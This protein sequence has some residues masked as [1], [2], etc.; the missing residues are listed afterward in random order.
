MSKPHHHYVN[1]SFLDSEFPFWVRKYKHTSDRIPHSHDFVE[2]V[3][4]TAGEALHEY[5]G[6]QYPIGAGDV[7]IINPGE[8]HT[9][10]IA[11]GQELDII[12]C[13]FIPELLSPLLLQELQLVKE[14]DFLYVLPF[15]DGHQRFHHRLKLNGRQSRTLLHLLESMIEEFELREAGHRTLLKMKLIEVLVLLSRYYIREHAAD[16][17]QTAAAD[18]D[19]LRIRRIRGY[20]ERHYQSVDVEALAKLFRVSSRQLNRIMK[21][22]TGLGVMETVH[23]IRIAKARKLLLETNETVLAIAGQVGYESPSFFNRLFVRHEGCS[24]NKYR[25][26]AGVKRGAVGQGQ[27]R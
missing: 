11:E 9:Y 27:E 13:L 18:G 4:V 2:L 8:V 22:R 19:E 12:N 21:S 24:P 7:F 15:L 3:Y 23:R 26:A 17:E 6:E 5:E 25:A 14:M 10:R 20:L 16:G 1:E